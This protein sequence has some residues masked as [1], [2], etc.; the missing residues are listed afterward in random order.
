MSDLIAKIDV[1]IESCEKAIRDAY[2]VQEV[3]NLERRIQ[4]LMKQRFVAYNTKE[5]ENE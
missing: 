5:I 2:T 3:E 4:E 1:E